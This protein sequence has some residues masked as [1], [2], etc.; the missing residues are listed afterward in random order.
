MIIIVS[1]LHH[2]AVRRLLYF[3]RLLIEQLSEVRLE[4]F[5]DSFTVVVVEYSYFV[6]S[7][8]SIKSEHNSILKYRLAI[9][10]AILKVVTDSNMYYPHTCVEQFKSAI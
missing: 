7:V 2:Q 6:V 1:P 5:H 10:Y 9:L 8:P 3:P 4:K